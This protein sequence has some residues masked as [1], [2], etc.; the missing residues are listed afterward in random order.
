MFRKSIKEKNFALRSDLFLQYKLY[1]NRLVGIIRESKNR[2]FVKFFQE[3][4]RNSKKIWE[5]V[6]QLTNLKTKKKSSK[7]PINIGEK[8]VSDPKIVANEFNAYFSNI[9]DKVRAKIPETKASYKEYLSKRSRRSFFFRPTDKEEVINIIN[10]LDQSKS[11]GPNSIPNRILKCVIDKIALILSKIFNISISKGKFIDAL[12]LVKVV[13][14]YKN[15]GSPH[16]TGNYRPISLLSNVDKIFEKL[17]HKRMTNYLEVNNILY[18]NQFGFRHKNS[19]IHSLICLTENIRNAIEKGNLACGIFIDLQKAFDTVDH[20][21]LLNKLYNYGFRGVCNDW[22]RSYL[23]GR[24]QF[25]Q[26]AGECSSHKKVIHGV[27]Q[28]SVLG[29]LLFLI[30]IN[31]LPNSLCSGQPYIFAD[32][33]ALLYIERNAKA[34]QKRINID[35]KLLLKWLKANKISLNVAK[36]ETILFK[37]QLKSIKFQFKIKLDGQRLIFQN[38]A[39]Y[40]GVQIDKN[41]NWSYHQEKV[42]NNL[43]QINGMLSRIRYYLPKDMLKNIYFALFHSK[44]TYAIQIWGQSLNHNSRL[45]KL[46]KS[47]VRLITFSNFQAASVPIFKELSIPP[48]YNIVLTLNIKLAHKTLNLESPAAVQEILDLKYMQ[49]SY[50]TRSTF[51][52]LLARPYVRTTTFGY[53]SIKNKTVIHW[54]TLQSNNKD[55]D[56]ATCGPSMIAKLINR[57]LE[58]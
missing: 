51:L 39:K 13:P 43:R 22:L 20:E 47:A 52:K 11:S 2:H 53:K 45:T 4:L 8:V 3:N 58:S 57:F 29:P 36:T 24:L 44:L 1:R 6:N 31:D 17:V 26:I 49:N 32:D 42:A 40:L 16:E 55:V 9:A 56:L 18:K 28:G 38:C 46:Q 25:V 12:K 27:P 35:M 10:N 5:G 23:T 50:S 34:L 15:K 48:T 21:I 33:T 14:V 37:H 7:I 41:L 30:Y 19:T 54:N